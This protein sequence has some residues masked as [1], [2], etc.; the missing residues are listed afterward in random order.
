MICRLFKVNVNYRAVLFQQCSTATDRM[1]II[2]KRIPMGQPW[3]SMMWPANQAL[4]SIRTLVDASLVCRQD[5]GRIRYP[6]A[7]VSLSFPSSRSSITEREKILLCFRS[8]RIVCGE[9]SFRLHS[10]GSRG[11]TRSIAELYFHRWCR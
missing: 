8:P 9:S 2:C 4:L 10:I 11:E 6:N 3:G 1:S 5:N 7:N